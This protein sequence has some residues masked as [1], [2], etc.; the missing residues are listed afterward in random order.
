MRFRRRR[1]ARDRPATADVVYAAGPLSE[2]DQQHARLPAG[3]NRERAFAPH[4]DARVLHPPGRCEYCDKYADWQHLRALWGIAF[5]GEPAASDG[6]PCPADHARPAGT[7]ADHR[8]W[9]GN[10][11]E[12]Y[13][14]P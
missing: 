3:W 9:P 6:L 8:N 11:P 12:G 4:C 7:P 13:P 14:P 5:T 1:P 2:W 10:T